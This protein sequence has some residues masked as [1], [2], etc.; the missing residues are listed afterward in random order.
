MVKMLTLLEF[1]LMFLSF[2]SDP[3]YSLSSDRDHARSTFKAHTG[4][5][6]I[7]SSD[8]DLLALLLKFRL[9]KFC[10]V[11]YI[12]KFFSLWFKFF[13]FVVYQLIVKELIHFVCSDWSKSYVCLLCGQIHALM[14][15]WLLSCIT[16]GL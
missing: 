6:R 15:H 10:D 16:Q 4:T 9:F 11:N 3:L 7:V 2:F 14:H 5:D 1:R 13:M 12:K 8:I